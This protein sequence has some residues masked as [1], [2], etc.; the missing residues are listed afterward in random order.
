MGS[1]GV[2][3]GL[4]LAAN[5]QAQALPGMPPREAP[6][7]LHPPEVLLPLRPFAA[8]VETAEGRRISFRGERVS[9]TTEAWLIEQGAAQS[10]DLLLLADRIR[11]EPATGLLT[12]EGRIR[13]E[14]A[15]VRLR[16][17]RLRMDWH[18]R[19][20][21]AWALEL[22]VP[23]HWTLRASHVAFTSLKLWDFQRVDV[24]ACPEERPGW[25]ARL[26]SLKVDL[27]GFATLRNLWLWLGPVPTY[28]Y[29]PWGIYPAQAKRSSGLLPMSFSPSG[30]MGWNLSIPYFQTLGD[31]ADLT[32]S[33]DY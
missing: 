31:R 8:S 3:A 17:E 29:L 27:E 20:G 11:Y 4:S 22:E 12:A 19:T 2:L 28:Y 13:L 5:L 9:E 15:G 23:P 14:A 25:T 32:V 26:S 10:E 18:Q 33:P 30:P 6:P 1:A 21:E 24:T 16:C 7:D